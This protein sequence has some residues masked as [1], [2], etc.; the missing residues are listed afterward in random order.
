[1]TDNKQL[2]DVE[3]QLA[4]PEFGASQALVDGVTAEGILSVSRIKGCGGRSRN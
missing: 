3:D 4:S 1:M 2:L